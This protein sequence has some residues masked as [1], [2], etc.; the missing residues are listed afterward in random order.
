MTAKQDYRPSVL[1]KGT[2][3]YARPSLHTSYSTQG[4]WSHGVVHAY[5]V[6]KLTAPGYGLYEVRLIPEDPQEIPREVWSFRFDMHT[7]EEHA[8]HVLVS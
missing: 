4:L 6:S 3:V 8:K 5:I 2:E 1:R 7:M